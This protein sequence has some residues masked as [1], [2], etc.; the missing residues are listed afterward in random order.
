MG[1]PE[2]AVGDRGILAVHQDRGQGSKTK[3]LSG[4]S[5]GS[6]RVPG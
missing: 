6:S 3:D 1:S 2:P 4:Y 5:V